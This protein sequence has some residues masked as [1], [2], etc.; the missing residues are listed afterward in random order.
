MHFRHAFVGLGLSLA[1]LATLK[2]MK[3]YFYPYRVMHFF[4]FWRF[5]FTVKKSC[6]LVF[7]LL[8]SLLSVCSSITTTSSVSRETDSV[9]WVFL[10]D[11]HAPFFQSSFQSSPIFLLSLCSLTIYSYFLPSP[12]FLCFCN[13]NFVPTA[14]KERERENIQGKIK[15]VELSL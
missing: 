1:C 10:S 4:H 8:F 3:P 5:H 9:V 2:Y 13:S 7:P 15:T 12:F 11:C 14:N 6:W